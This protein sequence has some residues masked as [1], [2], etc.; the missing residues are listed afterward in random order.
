MTQQDIHVA[1]IL[2]RMS[3]DVVL[4]GNYQIPLLFFFPLLRTTTASEATTRGR[5]VPVKKGSS[6]FPPPF[7][8]A[9]E[10]DSHH[11]RDKME[12]DLFACRSCSRFCYSKIFC[13]I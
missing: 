12:H 1:R 3:M 10:I 9:D 11:D 7:S 5:E 6:F 8:I 13:G 4:M 2:L